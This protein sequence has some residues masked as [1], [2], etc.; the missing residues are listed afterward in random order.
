MTAER[1]LQSDVLDILFEDRNKKYGAYELRRTYP[2]RVKKA[3]GAMIFIVAVCSAGYLFGSIKQNNLLVNPDVTDTISLSLL[4]EPPK[5]KQEEPP[6]PKPVVQENVAQVKSTTPII[7]PDKNVPE[8]EVPPIDAIDSSAIGTENIA[9]EAIANGQQ[10]VSREE[11]VAGG[12]GDSDKPVAPE[13]AMP[14]G[15]IDMRQADEMPEY[16][17]G[18]QALIRYM[19]N[20][21]TSELE[22]GVKYVIRA[23]FI[24]D[25]TGKVS[26]T[27]ILSSDEAGLNNQVLKALR[28]MKQWK[29]GKLHGR[30]VAVRFTMPVTFVGPEE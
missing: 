29:P 25:E 12:K 11:G 1:I 6:R 20:N 30:N 28:K 2:K 22:P 8:V 4:D 19:V 24:I 5:P 23:Q 15:P 18:S 21:L 17:G 7:E 26:E 16:P 13:P 3:I 10:N 14:T 9:G 27:T